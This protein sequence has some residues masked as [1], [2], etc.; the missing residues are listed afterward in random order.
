MD[1]SYIYLKKIDI[2]QDN[3]FTAH[4]SKENE[5]QK[6]T[7]NKENEYGVTGLTINSVLPDKKNF[8]NRKY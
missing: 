4:F 8:K 3:I 6:V 2:D 1:L 5:I 7:F